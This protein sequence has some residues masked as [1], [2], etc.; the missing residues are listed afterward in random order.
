MK[1]PFQTFALMALLFVVPG[2]SWYYLQSGLNYQKDLRAE[3]HNYKTLADFSIQTMDGKTITKA[4]L[5]DKLILF[6][7]FNSEQLSDDYVKTVNRLH[8]QFD[9]SG[10]LNFVFGELNTNILSQDL[11]FP[12]AD[13]C[14]YINSSASN[15]FIEQFGLPQIVKDRTKGEAYQINPISTPISS[16]D[17]FVLCDTIGIVKNYYAASDMTQIQR[18]IEHVAITLPREKEEDPVL[19]RDSEK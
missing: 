14:Y 19:R 11:P 12:E 16:Y 5:E 6:S 10:G 8:E 2:V 4:D 7:F 1:R 17:Y 9:N 13:D 3:L 18:M 15:R